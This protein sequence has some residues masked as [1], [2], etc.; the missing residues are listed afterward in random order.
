L[1]RPVD[2]R[3]Y[4]DRLESPAVGALIIVAVIGLLIA[5]ITA[6]AQQRRDPVFESSQLMLVDQ[7]G[8]LALAPNGDLVAKL[9]SLRVKY[10]SLLLS[11][12]V[13]GAAAEE[14]GVEPAQ[15]AGRVRANAVPE[16]LI[17]RITARA[18]NAEPAQQ[19]AAAMGAA[20]GDHVADEQAEFD[21]PEENRVEVTA[22][23]PASGAT[24][25]EPSTRRSLS[26]GAVAGLVAAGVIY[27]VLGLVP[28]F[29]RSRRG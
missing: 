16:S 12:E 14:L 17:I 8:A 13:V 11:D 1:S 2:V 22:L 19:L 10:V 25:V 20:L 28:L 24:Q 26:S 15:I 29:G 4:V 6:A 21:V 9:S 18:Q 23:R 27:L 3:G 7:P 5:A